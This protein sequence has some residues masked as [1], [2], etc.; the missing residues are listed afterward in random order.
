[1]SEARINIP[2]RRF[3]ALLASL[4]I[5]GALVGWSLRALLGALY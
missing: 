4:W 5:S 1:M 3:W 2:A